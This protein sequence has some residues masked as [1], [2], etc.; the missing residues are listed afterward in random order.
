MKSRKPLPPELVQ[1][2]A[3]PSEPFTDKYVFDEFLKRLRL[4]LKHYDIDEMD[5]ARWAKLSFQLAR[6]FVPGFQ[7]ENR[8]KRR[9]GR[10]P[11]HALT[12]QRP[13]KVGRPKRWTSQAQEFLLSI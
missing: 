6:D 3:L 1:P 13:R 12:I 9:R 4:L 7:L 10:P 5:S 2:I 11:K 8:R